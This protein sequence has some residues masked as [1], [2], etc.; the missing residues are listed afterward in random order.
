VET[1]IG[2]FGSR[3]EHWERYWILNTRYRETE[4]SQR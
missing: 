4:S 2:Q 3:C 1:N